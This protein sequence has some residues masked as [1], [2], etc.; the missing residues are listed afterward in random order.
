MCIQPAY[1]S[2]HYN[3]IHLIKINEAELD[4]PKL[5]LLHLDWV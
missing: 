3:F 5:M 2:T 4:Q 1:C